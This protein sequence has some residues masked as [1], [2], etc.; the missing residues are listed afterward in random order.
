MRQALPFGVVGFIAFLVDVG[1]FNL[2]RLGTVGLDG[3]AHAP[4]LAKSVSVTLATIT[5]W[6]GNRAWTFRHRRRDDAG[7]ELAIF[8]VMCTIGLAIALACLGISHYVLNLRSPLADNVSANGVGLVLGTAFRF[9]AYRR[10]VFNQVPA[11]RR[12]QARAEATAPVPA[13]RIPGSAA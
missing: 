5:A 7:Q 2:F 12:L 6:A 13:S 11:K 1:V 10:F 8:V 9:W 3:W 4:L